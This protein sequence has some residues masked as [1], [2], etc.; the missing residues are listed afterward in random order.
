M[1]GNHFFFVTGLG[2]TGVASCGVN[3][4]TWTLSSDSGYKEISFFKT[5]FRSDLLFFAFFSALLWD[6]Y[7]FLRVSEGCLSILGG[8]AGSTCEF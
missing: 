3:C 4:E 6:F 5:D 7:C 8:E 2:C 1:L